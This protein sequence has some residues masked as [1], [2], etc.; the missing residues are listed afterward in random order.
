[1][2]FFMY[3]KAFSNQ[4]L[5]SHILLLLLLLLLLGGV[6]ICHLW[7]HYAHFMLILFLQQYSTFFQA[8]TMDSFI[9]VH[10]HDMSA[11]N[12]A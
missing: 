2:S 8:L 6:W 12:V 1:M 4:K 3:A 11:M 9:K 7:S 10:S 5:L